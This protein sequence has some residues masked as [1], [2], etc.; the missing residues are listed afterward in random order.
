MKPSIGRMVHFCGTDGAVYAATV[1]A[2][3]NDFEPFDGM[4][5]D[6][7]TFGPQSIYF[8]QAVYFAGF[9]GFEGDLAAPVPGRWNWPP[10]VGS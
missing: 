5:V 2:V 7:V 1:T 10:R 6:L 9:E 3:R 8:H 4:V